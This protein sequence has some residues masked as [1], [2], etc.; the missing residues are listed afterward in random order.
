MPLLHGF[1]TERFP[2]NT[3]ASLIQEQRFNPNNTLPLVTNGSQGPAA[4]TPN[5]GVIYEDWLG[6]PLRGTASSDTGRA[7]DGLDPAWW[8][9]QSR[10]VQPS[11]LQEI[12]PT[13]ELLWD[14]VS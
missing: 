1:Q 3:A 4:E 7:C 14:K 10:A 6:Q 8:C 9:C 12:F 11:A 2:P 13:G 5:P